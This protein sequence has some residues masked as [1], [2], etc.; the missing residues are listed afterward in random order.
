MESKPDSSDPVI[1]E[2]RELRRKISAKFGHDPERLVAY[3]QELEKKHAD[4]MIDGSPNTDQ[5]AA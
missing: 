1:D 3:Y 4:R 2:I 5:P